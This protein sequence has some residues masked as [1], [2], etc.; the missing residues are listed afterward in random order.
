MNKIVARCQDG[1]RI[2]G[3][4]NDFVPTKDRFHV[5]ITDSAP[6]AKP[7]EVL[8]SD[9]K[10]VFFVKDFVGNRDYQAVKEF[11]AT[12]PPVGRKIRVVFKDGEVMIGTTQGYQPGRPGFFLVPADA[13]SNNE[14][15]FIVTAATKEIS[16]V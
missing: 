13:K 11:D 7:L 12:K 10:A 9:L 14:R 15:C 2:K 5:T 6:S 8:M 4:T 16:F 3:D 1:R